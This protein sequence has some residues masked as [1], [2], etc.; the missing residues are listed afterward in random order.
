MHY[1]FNGKYEGRLVL[2]SFETRDGVVVRASKA[3]NW[4]VGKPV[5]ALLH[6]LNKNGFVTR[7]AEKQG[8]M[9]VK[10]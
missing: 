3:A 5:Y 9:K 4:A 8:V 7:V 10:L 2:G 6:W 1:D